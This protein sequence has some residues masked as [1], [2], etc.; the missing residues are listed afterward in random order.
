MPWIVYFEV[1]ILRKVGLMAYKIP[2][3]DLNYGQEEI[4][5]FQQYVANGEIQEGK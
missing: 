4:R 2:L 3:F 1:Q 5:A